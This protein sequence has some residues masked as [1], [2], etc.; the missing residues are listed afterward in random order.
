MM[1]DDILLFVKVVDS[2]SIL[3]VEKITNLAKST[4]SRKMQG[5]EQQLGG[6]IF[7]R[8]TRGIELTMLGYNLYE[9]FR[10]YEEDLAQKLQLVNSNDTVARGRLNVLLP[11]T[12]S[13]KFIIPQL[14][15][16]LENNPFLK[17]NIL[18]N[19]REFNMQKEEYDIAVINYPPKQ[20]TQKFRYLA[21]DKIVVATTPEYLAKVGTLDKLEEVINQPIVGRVLPDGSLSDVA[22]LYHELNDEVIPVKLKA[23]FYVNNFLE[24]KNF[25]YSNHGI[26]AFPLHYIND[27]LADKRLIRLLPEYHAGIVDYYLLRNIPESDPRYRVFLE[28]LNTCLHQ[29][30]LSTTRLSNDQLFNRK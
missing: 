7:N 20:Q 6:Q 2:G 12:F 4:I 14:G 19:F 29:N 21:S 1:I 23:Q 26:S 30:S 24:S 11:V 27:E 8:N 17:I 18:H 5:L 3:A 28:F 9:K 15:I 10:N 16:F 13:D 25:V 22:N